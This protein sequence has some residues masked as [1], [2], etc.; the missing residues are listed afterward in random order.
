MKKLSIAVLALA[1]IF[2]L[3]AC[4]PKHV[5]HPGA[6]NTFDSDSYD[7]LLVTDQVIK[8]TKDELAA[9]KFPGTLADKVRTVLNDLIRG[10]NVADN[11]YKEYHAA[12][13]AGTA[14]T[15]QSNAVT[16]SLAQMKTET[17][18]LAAVKAGQ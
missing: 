9:G 8:T 12:A 11:A 4:G 15:E 18:A 6:A 14:T 1:L 16:N 5:N 7:A 13:L 10:Y 2:S 17:A 3:D